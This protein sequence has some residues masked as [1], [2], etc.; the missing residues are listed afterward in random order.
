L[1][2][3]PASQSSAARRGADPG[4][5]SVESEALGTAEAEAGRMTDIDSSRMLIRVEHGKGGK[6]LY[7]MLSV[8]LLKI[9]RPG[10]AAANLH[11]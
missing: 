2:S 10:R 11:C 9:L 4:I 3:F 8:Q 5:Q 6:D 1:A 7:V